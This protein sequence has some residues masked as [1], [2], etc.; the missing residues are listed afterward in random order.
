MVT[1]VEVTTIRAVA[2]DDDNVG[3]EN[4]DGDDV[5]MVAVRP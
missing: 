2:N 3:G 5:D 1:T 4:E